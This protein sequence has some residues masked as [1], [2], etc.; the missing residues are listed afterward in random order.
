[1]VFIAETDTS[2]PVSAFLVSISVH[3]THVWLVAGFATKPERVSF[4]SSDRMNLLL[5]LGLTFFCFAGDRYPLVL[6]ATVA[7]LNSVS[8]HM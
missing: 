5:L 4:S 1:M 8:D 2:K 6:S 7:A 3:R